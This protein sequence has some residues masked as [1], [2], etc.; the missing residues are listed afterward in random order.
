MTATDA[1][2]DIAKLLQSINVLVVDG[3]QFM[4]KVSRTLLTNAG[5][6]NVHEVADGI[7]ALEHIRMFGPDLVIL[8]WELP[9]LGGI[10][11]VKIVR[12]P[13]VFPA[14]D[15]PIIMLTGHG[16]R[17]RVVA[18]AA[19]GVNEF[20]I[21]PASARTLRDRM[22]SILTCPRPS[23]QVGKYYGPAPRKLIDV[24]PRPV[25]LSEA[26]A[27]AGIAPDCTPAPEAA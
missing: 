6:K 11:L 13:G 4:R 23:V 5:V 20:L 27:G 17:W 1:R 21:K 9:L 24:G 15:V 22:V 25:V 26:E 8:D 10:E 14:P 18:A 2:N 3:N 16:E 19:S 7:A 12:S